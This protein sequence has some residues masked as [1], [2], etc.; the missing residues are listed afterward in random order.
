[1]KERPH[2]TELDALGKCAGNQRRSDDGEHQLVDHEALLGDGAAV[3]GV[4]R[5]SH[6]AQEG[7][8]KAADEAVA[9]SKASE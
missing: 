9:G 2:G 7:M 8:L 4:G 5:E 3:V 1:V 6:A